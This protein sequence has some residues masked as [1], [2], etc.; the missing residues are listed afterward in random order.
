MVRQQGRSFPYSITNRGQVHA[1]YARGKS[2]A[3]SEAGGDAL[4]EGLWRNLNCAFTDNVAQVAS[5]RAREDYSYVQISEVC[6]F[7]Q[8]LGAPPKL[9]FSNVLLPITIPAVPL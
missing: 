8:I 1:P 9:P 2:V 3:H 5:V 6:D 4:S 7:R